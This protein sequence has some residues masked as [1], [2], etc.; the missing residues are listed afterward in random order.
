MS[1]LRPADRRND[2]TGYVLNEASARF[3]WRHICLFAQTAKAASQTVFAH[4]QG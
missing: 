2:L 4:V 3:E 1:S